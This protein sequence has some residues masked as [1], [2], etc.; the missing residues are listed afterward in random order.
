MNRPLHN[1]DINESCNDDA[2]KLIAECKKVLDP[3]ITKWA[4]AGFSIRGINQVVNDE[5]NFKCNLEGLKR[6]V[7]SEPSSTPED[8]P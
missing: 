3:V 6:I 4:D 2:L 7:S 8:K 1:D 5:V